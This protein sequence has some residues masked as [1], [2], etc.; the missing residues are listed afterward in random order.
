MAGFNDPRWGNPGSQASKVFYMQG[1]DSLSDPIALPGHAVTGASQETRE[2]SSKVIMYLR[3]G[4]QIPVNVP[5]AGALVISET[6]T[7]Q[8]GPFLYTPALQKARESGDGLICYTDFAIIENCS[9]NPY[10]RI[11]PDAILSSPTPV[12]DFIINTSD[13]PVAN[14]EQ[15]NITVP[16][17]LLQY[18]P[19]ARVTNITDT[20]LTAVAFAEPECQECQNVA[21]ATIVVVGGDATAAEAYSTTDR[22]ANVT[23][24]TTNIPVG[25]IPTDVYAEGD[26]ILI[27][28]ASGTPNGGTSFSSDGTNFSLDTNLTEAVYG[29]AKVGGY[30][31]AVGGNTAGGI[32]TSQDG[33]TWTA[34]AAAFLTGIT[35]AILRKVAVVN[36][37][38]YIVG[39][40]A[41]FL[42]GTIGVGGTLAME[43]LGSLLP[44]PG[45]A[46]LLDVVV[47]EDNKI[48]NQHR[49]AV[50]GASNYGAESI[51]SGRT[52][53]LSSF[54]GTATAHVGG[55]RHL[56]MVGVTTNLYWRSQFLTQNRW[57]EM[58]YAGAAPAGNYNM[59]KAA[60][61][62]PENYGAAV[63]VSG[64]FVF[65]FPP[66]PNA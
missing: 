60:P 23:T 43:D 44:T 57:R 59:I 66:H 14:S 13:Q 41:E 9:D 61:R 40:S 45:G 15:F 26:T 22:F 24:L 53:T 42:R 16:R 55:S 29:V 8:P 18:T 31:I 21:N 54:P 1:T 37:L 19:M 17:V 65:I 36:N 27:G 50:S 30:Y 64:D 5:I 51:D 4:V 63:T 25:G 32:W 49:V 12:E 6:F 11:M 47:Y 33:L 56:N 34:Q 58:T 10:A 3:N 48:T 35:A 2:V 38:V 20:P 7:I 28:F 46:N 52:F 62:F 39:D